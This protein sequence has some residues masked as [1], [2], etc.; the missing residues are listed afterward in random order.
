MKSSF[1]HLHLHS[2]YSLVNG[3]ITLSGLVEQTLQKQAPA[4]ALTDMGNLYGAVKFFSKCVSAGIKP[5]IGAEIFLDNPDKVNQPYIL[6]LLVQNAAGYKNLSKLISMG[7]Q[8]GQANNRPELTKQWLAEHN[9]GLICLSGGLRGDL[10]NAMLAAR[11]NLVNSVLEEYLQIFPNRFYIEIQRVGKDYEEEYI[12]AAA[13]L[14]SERGLPLVAT[15]DVHFMY[16]QDYEAHEVRVCINEGRVL[17]DPRR[18]KHHTRS[19]SLKSGEEMEALFADLPSAIANTTEIAKRCNFELHTGEYFLPDF[20][21]PEGYTEE[22]YLREQSF[23]GLEHSLARRFPEGASQENIQEYNERMEFELQIILQMGFPGYFLIVADFI[24]WAKQNDVPVGPGRG[25]GA[26]SIVAYALGITDLDPIKHQLL[27][28]RF[29]NP[30]RVSMPDFDVDFCI[31]GRERVIDYVANKYGRNKVS[32]IITYGTMAAKGVIRDVGRVLGMSYG[33]V[34]GIAKLIPFE[35]G[36]TLTKALEQ[37]PELRERYEQEDEITELVDMGL[38]LEGIAR[39][40]GK[41]AGGV[42]IAPTDLTDFTPLYCERDSEQIVSQYDKDDLETIGLVKFDFLGLK[43]LTIIDWAVK[44]INASLP[45]DTK[46][47]VIEALELDDAPTYEILKKGL[48]TAI[49]QLESSGMKE[50]IKNLL[51]DQFED[52][53]A[54]VALYRPGPLGAG[55]EKVY[56]DRKHGKEVTK[57]PHPMLEPILNN[58]Y[59][60]ILYQEQVMEIA[61][62]MA[63]YSLG[64]ADILRRA[65][66][67]KKASEMAEQRE[68]FERGAA[69]RGVDV[70]TAKDV[71]DLME[72]FAEYGFNKSHS[73]AYA[74]VAYQTAWL[75][76]H[77]PSHFM[78]AC[79]S[80]DMEN[81]DKVVI[82]LNEAVELGLVVEHPD[83]NRCEYQFKAYD[84]THIVYGLGAIKGIGR[85]VIEAIIE[86]RAKGG[87][88]ADLY[89]L[90]ARMDGKRVNRRALEALIKAGALDELGTHR[91]SLM[92]SVDLALEAANQQH[93]SS[94]AGQND[95]FGIVAPAETVQV[96]QNVQE[97]KKEELLTAEKDT[98]GLYLSGHPIDVYIDELKQFTSCRLVDVDVGGGKPSKGRAKTPLTLAG[99]VVGVRV[100]NT[101]SG[102]R[103]AFLTLDDKSARMEIGVYGELYDERREV[104]RKDKVL[105]VKGKAS[106]DHFTGNLRVSADELFDIEQA[107]THLSRMLGIRLQ[108]DIMTREMV[109]QLREL[110]EH[111]ELGQCRVSLEYLGEQGYCSLQLSKD[112]MIVP[113]P[114]IMEKLVLLV[115]HDNLRVVY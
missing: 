45:I 103:M 68:I 38:K 30:E 6:V 19:Q 109:G 1:V 33:H 11:P 70:Q 93:R 41:H 100:L 87:H 37:E 14:A 85:P 74:L 104:I 12:S 66:G 44:A 99:L 48:T 28:E 64:G 77:Y 54:L 8:K 96:Y 7:Y 67:K 25:S 76:A 31:E 2:E 13:L 95:M 101:K 57:Y 63:G 90:C 112:W 79:M 39:N 83:I 114:L 113:E 36:M 80:A 71:F 91:A 29:L 75:K 42:V 84:D 51:P 88:F 52:I 73:A 115:G 23:Q 61:R 21:I 49:F 111:N 15:N 56:C 110:L 10:G 65:M 46:P 3:T 55:M 27:F 9:E 69:E 62:V 107:R 82:L 98:L 18:T 106:H 108:G 81:T 59:G 53:V 72:Y 58:T 78:A 16:E 40:V 22:S 24:Q 94:A 4:V 86:A 105:V 47:L 20:P 89:D 97:W 34:D 43:T 50:L 26:G 32:Q 102:S 92:A 5:L 60:V 17:N 35:L